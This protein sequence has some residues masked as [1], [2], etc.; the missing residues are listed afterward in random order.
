MATLEINPDY[1]R[2]LTLKVRAVM[3][4]ETATFPDE[5]SNATDDPLVGLQDSPDDQSRREI[6]KEIAGLS[7]REQAELVA[8]MWLGRGDGEP[9]EWEALVQQAI[10]SRDAPTAKYLLDHPLLAEYWLD[11]FESLGLDPVV[12]GAEGV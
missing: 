11:G 8:L 5:G 1:V 3:G 9:E 10:D 2:M 6:V 7:E 12:S 4:K